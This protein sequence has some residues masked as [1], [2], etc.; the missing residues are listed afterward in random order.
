MERANGEIHTLAVPPNS[1]PLGF[2]MKSVTLPMQQEGNGRY[3]RNGVSPGSALFQKMEGIRLMGN[4]RGIPR[5]STR[6]AN[7]CDSSGYQ[8]PVLTS[9]LL[10]P[11]KL[12]INPP[13]ALA[14]SVT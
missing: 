1:A 14:G 10:P 3:R 11:K 13:L 12:E 4:T 2:S 8:T 5:G 7:W 9:F 6:N